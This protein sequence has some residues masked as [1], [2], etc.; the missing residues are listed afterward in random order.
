MRRIS[1][2]SAKCSKASR[3]MTISASSFVEEAKEQV[4]ETPAARA[5]F[6]GGFEK[7]LANIETDYPPR[8]SLG[9]FNGIVPSATPEVDDGFPRDPAEKI[10]PTLEG[11]FRFA[12]VEAFTREIC[13]YR[14]DGLQNPILNVGRH[15]PASTGRF[16]AACP[17]FT[18]FERR[19]SPHDTLREYRNINPPRSEE[20][21]TCLGRACVPVVRVFFYVI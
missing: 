9:H 4:L 15:L 13:R 6:P 16:D 19:A 1:A 2:G 18:V 11:Q 3:E 5:F 17:R 20:R 14:A 21:R 12:L 7:I 8:P 10:L